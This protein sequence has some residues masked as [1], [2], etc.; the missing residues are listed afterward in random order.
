M[1]ILRL[2]NKKNFS[3]VFILF[4]NIA[5]YAE[6]QPVDIWNIEKKTTIT[7]TNKNEISSDNETIISIN[8]EADIYKMQSEKKKETIELGEILNTKKTKIYGLYDPKDFDLDIHMWSNSNGDEL[9]N[10][11]VRLNK[12]DL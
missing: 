4:C 7:E 1:K 6:D 11:F 9:K 3:I 8:S 5:S 10:I 2:L 12:I